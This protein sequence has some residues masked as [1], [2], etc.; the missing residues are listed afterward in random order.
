LSQYWHLSLLALLTFPPSLCICCLPLG[1]HYAVSD[2]PLINKVVG[3]WS[4]FGL[5]NPAMWEQQVG[6]SVSLPCEAWYLSP[7]M[8]VSP[9]VS[10]GALVQH[11]QHNYAHHS[12]TN[13]YTMVSKRARSPAR[14]SQLQ[15]VM[16]AMTASVFMCSSI[17][18]R[19]KF[20]SLSGPWL[21]LIQ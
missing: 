6:E 8:S 10:D 13:D 19:R 18:V 4:I 1:V 7:S 20:P 3:Y 14:T 11:T 17:L 16:M 2:S 21:G 15:I 12:F 5:A 9:S